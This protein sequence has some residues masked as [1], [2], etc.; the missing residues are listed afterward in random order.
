MQHRRGGRTNR[1]A[2]VKLKML[3]AFEDEAKNRRAIVQ[4]ESMR[5]GKLGAALPRDGGVL[6]VYETETGNP[7]QAVVAALRAIADDFERGESPVH[8]ITPIIPQAEA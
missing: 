7:T 5:A 3:F 2:D 6:V 4:V 1:E 8:D